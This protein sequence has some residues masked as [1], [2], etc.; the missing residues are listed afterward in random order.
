M[1]LNPNIIL[2]LRPQKFDTPDPVEQYTKGIQLKG[3]MSQQ[4]VADQTLADDRSSRDAFSASGGDS[5]KYLQALASSGNYKAYAAAMKQKQDQEKAVVDM[6]H[7]RAQT[8]QAQASAGKS[9]VD[10]Q[11]ATIERVSS[12]LSTAKDPQSYA[13]ARAAVGKMFPQALANLPEQFDPMIVQSTIA[14]GMKR[15]EQLKAEHDAKVAA[16]TNRHNT[17]TEGETGRH[18][19]SS[20]GIQIRGQNMVDSRSREATAATVTKPFEVTGPD[21]NP[22]LVQQ[23]KAGNIKPVQGYSPKTA[24]DKPLNEG[25]S[26]AL[27]FGSRM[28]EADKV[29]ETLAKEG[30]NA[31]VPGSRAPGIGGVISALSTGNQQSLDQAKR[32]FMTAVLRRESGA[33]IAPSEF[34]TADKQYFPQ[35]GDSEKVLKQKAANRKMAI[36][37]VLIEVPEK[38]RASLQP[39]GGATGSFDSATKTKAGAS[40]SNW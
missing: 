14:G 15:S 32:D 5:S 39:R 22:I 24:A 7:T 31:S 28:R 29:L 40:V 34:A 6:D 17:T 8:T 37:G 18:N 30:T 12:I 26:K 13:A 11:V 25:Q 19:R 4:A 33:S 21:G 9:N 35:I 36:D 1:A 23:D 3:L 10:A 27:L 2:G 16:E 20:E 38:H